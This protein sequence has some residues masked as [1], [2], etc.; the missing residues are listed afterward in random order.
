MIFTLWMRRV[1]A[2]LCV[3]ALAGCAGTRTVGQQ[4]ASA[5]LAGS[6]Y[7]AYAALYLDDKGQPKYDPESLLDALEAGKA[8]NNAGLW[9]LSRDAF[10]AAARQ[11]NWKEDT[12]TPP[13]RSPT[14]WA[15][16]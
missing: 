13:Q 8:F 11:L 3:M 9:A 1:L 6:D 14:C 15:R 7:R 2:C 16:P 4:D 5:L 10:D 12:V